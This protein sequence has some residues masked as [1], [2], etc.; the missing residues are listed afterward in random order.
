MASSYYK[1]T[2]GAAGNQ[3]TFTLSGWFKPASSS[4]DTTLWSC[5]TSSGGSG[6]RSEIYINASYKLLVGINP[7][8]STWYEL[9][10]N[11]VL[12]DPSAWYHVVIA[13]DTTQ[14]VE[15]NRV[16]TY[17]NGVEYTAASGSYPT[18][19]L[20]TGW[21]ADTY[22]HQ[23]G[24]Y[25]TGSMNF[26]GCMSHTHFCDGTA[27]AASDFGEFDSTSG[28]W[29]AKTSPSVTYGS[30]GGFWKFASG[31]LTTDSSGSGNTLT[32][33]GTPTAT[34][35]NPDNNFATLT[36]LAD[37]YAEGTFS[38]GNTKWVSPTDG[39]H[40]Y[41]ISGHAMLAGLWY[42]EVKMKQANDSG[43]GIT[44]KE[45]PDSS[46]NISQTNY[47]AVYK[48]SDGYYQVN[49]GSST[50]YGDS[51][52][53]DDIIGIYVDLT[54]NKLYFAKNGTIQNS[55]TGIDITGTDAM[56][57][58]S[59]SSQLCYFFGFDKRDGGST[60]ECNFGNGYFG[61]DAI[62][63]AVADAGGEGLFKYNPS[64]GTFDGASK[65][66]RALC[67]NNIATYG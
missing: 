33:V 51:Y 34:K 62:S 28:I 66:F 9:T 49:G 22:D 56:T 12:R 54:A 13:Y 55:G 47:G 32:A 16:K 5:I 26:D 65:D 42:M 15:A 38:N 43:V 31:A 27:Y 39:N 63:G 60:F 11:N 53:T 40:R 6:P 1:Y 8:G 14:A 41:V 10:F 48:S 29:V 46:E 18:L 17:I 25:A 61:T 19:N 20:D 2:N 21:M 36:P 57:S 35:D 59:N 24:N 52:T 37:Y 4:G 7:S 44:D 67:T 50:A 30:N 45:Q 3:K 23:I 58:P 64:T